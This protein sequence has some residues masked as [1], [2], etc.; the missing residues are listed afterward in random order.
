[1]WAYKTT[2][3]RRHADILG[4]SSSGLVTTTLTRLVTKDIVILEQSNC[5]K[6]AHSTKQIRTNKFFSTQRN[7]L[8]FPKK[9]APQTKKLFLHLLEKKKKKQFSTK[10]KISHT[11]L[12]NQYFTLQEKFLMLPWK[13]FSCLSKK[14]KFSKQK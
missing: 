4:G 9:P 14:S 1:M 6:L 5:S 8:C 11:F 12:E 3:P 10:R 2:S 13:N 7:F